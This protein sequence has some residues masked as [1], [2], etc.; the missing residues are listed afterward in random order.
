MQPLTREQELWKTERY[1]L[2][3]EVAQQ[4]RAQKQVGEVQTRIL[5]GKLNKTKVQIGTE[6]GM[7]EIQDMTRDMEAIQGVAIRGMIRDTLAIRGMIQDMVEIRG[8][9]RDMVAIQ[10]TVEIQG[11]V[12]GGA[13]GVSGRIVTVS[14]G[15]HREPLPEGKGKVNESVNS[16][17]AATARR[18]H[19]V[20]MC[21]HELIK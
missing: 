21:I 17:R 8:M 5:A 12:V 6:V 14:G 18:E 20:T 11:M 7:A 16:M 10:D 4:M 9:T 19:H 15:H 13:I 3:G 2:V 1:L